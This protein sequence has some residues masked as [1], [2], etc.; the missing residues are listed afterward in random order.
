M[1]IGGQPFDSDGNYDKTLRGDTIIWFRY[2]FPDSRFDQ[3][4]EID[5]IPTGPTIKEMTMRH[6]LSFEYVEDGK[7]GRVVTGVEGEGHHHCYECEDRRMAKKRKWANVF[8][9]LKGPKNK[10]SLVNVFRQQN[11]LL[12][13]RINALQ[14]KIKNLSTLLDRVERDTEGDLYKLEESMFDQ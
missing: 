11:R 8:K 12:L 1:Y 5:I 13:K 3:R 4:P 6:E 2:T 14:T 9:S 10:F 7:H